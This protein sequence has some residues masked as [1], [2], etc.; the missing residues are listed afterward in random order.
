MI[1]KE[2]K[3]V[4]SY[5]IGTATREPKSTTTVGRAEVAVRVVQESTLVESHRGSY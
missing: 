4:V 5:W 1:L 3:R 2:K